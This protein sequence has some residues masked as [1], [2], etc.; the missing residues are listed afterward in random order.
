MISLEEY[1]NDI[2]ANLLIMSRTANGV[3]DFSSSKSK[4][5][6]IKVSNGKKAS[7][8]ARENYNRAIEFAY[9]NRN[10]KFLSTLE[11]KSFVEEIALIINEGITADNV[12]YRHGEE[13]V[14]Y[15]YVSIKDIDAAIESYTSKIIG[16]VNSENFDPYY[17]AAISEY[18]INMHGH[19]FADGCGKTSMIV[20]AYWFMRA[21]IKVASYISKNFYYS[22]EPKTSKESKADINRFISYIRII[23]NLKDYWYEHQNTIAENAGL[24]NVTFLEE[25]VLFDALKGNRNTHTMYYDYEKKRN[26]LMPQKDNYSIIVNN[27]YKPFGIIKY[28]DVK[29]CKFREVPFEYALK[30]N[31][32]DCTLAYWKFKYQELF[33]KQAL[34]KN[35]TFSI[36]SKVLLCEFELIKK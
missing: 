27:E 18:F 4:A 1:K 32:G 17:C 28:T 24:Y 26:N 10:R 11:I 3:L 31:K 15:N 16:N 35:L 25:D 5:N 20:S 2:N 36:F 9:N 30:E 12:L 19:F 8:I 7:K 21:G 13:S 23:H 34:E 33:E 22:F 29:E 14:L 6:D